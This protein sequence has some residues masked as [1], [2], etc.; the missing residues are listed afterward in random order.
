VGTYAAGDLWGRVLASPTRLASLSTPL[1][2]HLTLARALL[3]PPLLLLGVRPGVFNV[4]SAWYEPAV[5]AAL[6]VSNGLLGTCAVVRAPE[7][8]EADEDREAASLV[9]VSALYLGIAVGATAGAL[10]FASA[11]GSS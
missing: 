2:W 3:A 10:A 5:I 9:V 1:C 4:R 8:V 11:N 6:A 7:G